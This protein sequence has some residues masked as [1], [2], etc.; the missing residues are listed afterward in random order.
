MTAVKGGYYMVFVAVQL[1]RNNIGPGVFRN[2]ILAYEDMLEF[3]FYKYQQQN[4]SYL[5]T[6]VQGVAVP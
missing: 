5:Y 3:F 4:I 6:K 1:C 2:G